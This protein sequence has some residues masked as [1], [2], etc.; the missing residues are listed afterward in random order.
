MTSYLNE[1]PRQTNGSLYNYSLVNN[2]ADFKIV[3][4]FDGSQTATLIGEYKFTS[5]GLSVN[6]SEELPPPPPPP[7]PPPVDNNDV[8]YDLLTTEEEV[9][10]STNPN[11]DDSDNDGYLDGS[12]IVNLYSPV[13]SGES[14]IDSG[15]VTTF[16]NSEFGYSLWY[17]SAWVA[18]GMSGNLDVI[19]IA[20][21]SESGDVIYISVEENTNSLSIEERL[22]NTRLE[23]PDL[24]TTTLGQNG[25]A[26][27]QTTDKQKIFYFNDDYTYVLFYSLEEG[28]NPSFMT[29]FQMILN[30]FELIDD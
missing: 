29:T 19:V 22:E 21:N 12:E 13:A 8:D 14:L 17:P 15:L 5:N 24:L 10:Y 9:L 25:L 3:V 1:I 2:G 4:T 23:Y 18:D 6:D 26:A 11:N 7:P 20:T 28:V 16:T 30:S 27:W